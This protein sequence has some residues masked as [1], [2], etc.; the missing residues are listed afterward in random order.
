MRWK[1]V[2]DSG[3]NIFEIDNLPED[4]SFARVPML[5]Y[6]DDEEI[7]DT[8]DIDTTELIEKIYSSDK[9]GSACPSPGVYAEKFSGADNVIAFTITGTLSGSYSSALSGKELVLEENPEANIFV[10]DSKATAGEMDLLIRKT[11]ELIRAGKDFDAVVHDL[12]EYHKTTRLAYM[13]KSIENFVKNG[14]VNEFIGSVV[15]MLNI[16]VIGI[17]SDEGT[18]DMT[19][20]ARGEKRA[21]KAFIKDLINSRFNGRV[22]EIAHVHNRPLADE[23]AG[24]L[25]EKYPDVEITIRNTSGLCTLYTERGG[26]TVGYERNI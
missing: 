24:I 25:R 5:L 20:R 3:S 8:P 6:L 12:K 17:R 14:R 18:I 11:V 1:I 7:V 2:T 15:G 21:I 16:H 22:L 23:I 19:S 26:I 13:F 9:A 4:T 10:L